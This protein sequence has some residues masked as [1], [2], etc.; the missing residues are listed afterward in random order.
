MIDFVHSR[1]SKHR[2]CLPPLI[3]WRT[4]QTS[5]RFMNLNS[6]AIT[7][8]GRVRRQNED[9]FVCSKT[10]G[11]Y[12]VADGIGG[13]PAGALAAQT[14]VDSW[15]ELLESAEVEQAAQLIPLIEEIN[16]RVFTLG[17]DISM[18]T[19]IGSTLTAGVVSGDRLLIAHVGDSRCLRITE[20]H[21]SCITTDHSVENDIKRRRDQGETID[22]DDRYMQALTRCIGQPGTPEV[23]VHTQPLTPGDIYLF[24]TDGI[25]RVVSESELAKLLHRPIPLTERLALVVELANDRGGPDNATAVALEILPPASS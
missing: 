13:L 5:A 2:Y 16:L 11:T 3:E 18:E 25:T 15:I 23:D 1:R 8:I 20:N 21:V 24:A 19:G 6:A 22:V 17:E 12:G 7:D 14:A 4:I 9:R 10:D